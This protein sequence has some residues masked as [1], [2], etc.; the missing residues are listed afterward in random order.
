MALFAKSA[1]KSGEHFAEIVRFERANVYDSD[2]SR[3]ELSKLHLVAKISFDT[4]E[5]ETR[6]V[7]IID[8]SDHVSRPHAER[9]VLSRPANFA[10]G[11]G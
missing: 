10:P 9:L 5:S 6:K 2:R 3:Q 1:E 11:R 7:W 4:A 8:L